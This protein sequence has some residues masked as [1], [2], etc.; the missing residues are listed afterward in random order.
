MILLLVDWG[1]TVR[2]NVSFDEALL[3]AIDSAATEHGLTR[4]A[5]LARAAREKIVEGASPH[6]G[7]TRL[8]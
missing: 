7:R 6:C 1:R 4:S 2:A 5:F 3:E 8:A